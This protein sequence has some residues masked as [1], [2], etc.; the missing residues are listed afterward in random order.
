V[1][2][3]AEVHKKTGFMGNKTELKLLAR[4]QSEQ[5]WTMLS[6]EE[7]IPVEIANEY[8]AGV[9]VLVELDANQQIRKVQDATRHLVGIL[10][11]FSRM[12]DKFRTQ[13]EEIEGW[14]QSLIYQSQELT[15]RE[16]DI[17]ARTEEL[18]QLE[19]ESHKIKEQLQEFEATR[20]QILQLKED[21]ER[22]R[23][24]LE[25][26]W[27]RLRTAQQDQR[28]ALGD[29]Q[30]QALES[31]MNRLESSVLSSEFHQPLQTLRSS[32]TDQQ[33]ILQR[34]WD[35]LTQERGQVDAAQSE[36]TQQQEE[37]DR[38]WQTWHHDQESLQQLHIQ[39]RLQQEALTLKQ[40]QHAWMSQQLQAQQ[41]L[42]RNLQLLKEGG[43]ANLP[44]DLDT[45]RQMP[46]E[47]LEATVSRLQEEQSKL[48]QF[49]SD[50]EEELKLQQ[51]TIDA[52]KV[53][54]AQASEYDRMNLASE[55]EDEQ[56]NYQFLDDTLQGQRHTLQDRNAVLKL[57]QDI[58]NRRKG[59]AG[60]ENDLEKQVEPLLAQA[61]AQREALQFQLQT[62]EQEVSSLQATLQQMQSQVDSSTTALAQRRTELANQAHALNQ[63]QLEV[64]Q[65]RGRVDTLQQTLQP[66]Q[67]QLTHINQSLD[68]VWSPLEVTVTSQQQTVA[69][70]K[71]TIMSLV[72]AEQVG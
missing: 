64:G 43:S 61:V 50:Q 35:Q 33:A 10:K 63:R 9:L 1:L 25:E 42:E 3:L 36:L 55:L 21:I 56:Q 2:Y 68:I 58:L 70:L 19:S 13:E 52:L 28:P 27:G 24:Q 4:Q 49:V 45:L 30:V 31:L 18:Q 67:D 72:Q 66:I 59:I 57:H 15:R 8:N 46:L 54:M 32:G 71:H 53:K 11:N 47:E 38:A 29:E 12:R 60:S 48:S 44:I 65:L 51:E 34:F 26:A 39:S 62:L 69:E 23:V 20:T 41:D 22:D 5:N 14:K 6:G 17:E 40:G 16:V 7:M 37:L